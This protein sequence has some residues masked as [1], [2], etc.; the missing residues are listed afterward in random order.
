[1]GTGILGLGPRKDLNHHIWVPII[2]LRYKTFFYFCS[3]TLSFTCYRLQK[4]AQS[5]VHRNARV[6]QQTNELRLLVGQSVLEAKGVS[7]SRS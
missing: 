7:V 2:H 1:M 6:F 3:L 5:E 4:Q